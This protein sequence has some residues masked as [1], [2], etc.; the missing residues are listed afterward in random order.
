M[1]RNTQPQD[2]KL[3]RTWIPIPLRRSAYSLF[4][5]G[6]HAHTS[7]ATSGDIRLFIL[8]KKESP[9]CFLPR[10]HRFFSVLHL[11]SV[12][13]E[14]GFFRCQSVSEFLFSYVTP[15]NKVRRAESA[16]QRLDHGLYFWL[17]QVT[18]C[19][20]NIL[21]G[22]LCNKGLCW[23]TPASVCYTP[24]KAGQNGFLNKPE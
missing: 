4:D 17:N 24:A 14:N 13:Q 16:S 7:F 8:S 19:R 18:K 15:C 11:T 3:R 12:L 23:N 20:N 9:S 21:T 1:C 5:W 10:N 2:H 22:S 6:A